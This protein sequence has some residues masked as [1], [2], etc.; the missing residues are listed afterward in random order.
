[1]SAHRPQIAINATAWPLDYRS[2]WLFYLPYIA[3]AP[4]GLPCEAVANMPCKAA[5][6]THM[7]N[8]IA[9]SVQ[10]YKIRVFNLYC[11][12]TI[13]KHVAEHNSTQ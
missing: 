4:C 5:L 10:S 3:G 1:M 8:S 12:L 7:W 2:A 11:A 6:P 9:A 13:A